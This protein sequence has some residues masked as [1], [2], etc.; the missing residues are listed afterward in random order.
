MK[1]EVEIEFKNLL[2][3]A[4]FIS[5]KTHFKI[6]DEDFV[7]QRNYYF[8]TLEFS[9]AK[10]KSALRIREKKAE[11]ELTLK[12]PHA[13]GLLETNIPV[14]K[15]EAISFIRKNEF[16]KSAIEMKRIFAEIGLD[17]NELTYLGELVTYRCEFEYKNGLLA[18]DH[19]VYLDVEDYEIEY[20]VKDKQRGHHSFT[21]LLQQLNISKKSTKNKIK[22]F[23]DKK[24]QTM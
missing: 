21:Q 6:K 14:P 11:Y 2:S 17:S 8:D 7:E 13:N 24:R 5:V 10:H 20:E 1:Q 23:F 16:P 18:L 3:Y 19:S 22:R 15:H 12:Q 9:L 4:E